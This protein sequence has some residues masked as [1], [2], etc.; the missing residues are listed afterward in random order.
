MSRQGGGS[1]KIATQK[2]GDIIKKVELHNGRGEEVQRN[3]AV[4]R[5][6]REQRSSCP[7]SGDHPQTGQSAD[8]GIQGTGGR[9]S[10]CMATETVSLPQPSLWKRA[11]KVIELYRTKYCD[12]NFTHF[13]ELLGRLEGI[14]I[15]T[16][17]VAF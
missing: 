9:L 11:H 2:G 14:K 13:T 1:G 7:E 16:S 17:A 10:S 6:R 4:G 5:R 12:A 8:Q 15:S 3:Q